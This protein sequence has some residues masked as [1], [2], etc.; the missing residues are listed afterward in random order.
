MPVTTRAGNKYDLTAAVTRTERRRRRRA[1]MSTSE[2]A[3]VRSEHAAEAR[4]ARARMNDDLRVVERNEN[5][6]RRRTARARMNDER[7]AVERR[8]DTERRRTARARISDARRWART[9]RQLWTH[10]PVHRIPNPA[11][12]T[13]GQTSICTNCRYQF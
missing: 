12:I 13:L 2:L 9:S 7:R 10:L 3:V 4:A 11:P 1:G 8:E 6:D 5:T